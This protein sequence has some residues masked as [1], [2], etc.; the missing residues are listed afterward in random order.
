M[1]DKKEA[2]DFRLVVDML[3]FSVRAKV[4]RLR[5]QRIA[6]DGNWLGPGNMIVYIRRIPIELFL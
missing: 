6:G 4:C 2:T 5:S 1:A 3:G